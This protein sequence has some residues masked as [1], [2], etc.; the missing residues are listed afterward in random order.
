MGISV[1]LALFAW[2]A[3]SPDIDR[4]VSSALI[5]ELLMALL[6]W[7]CDWIGDRTGVRVG[8]VVG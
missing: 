4:C 7:G 8:V 1:V 3:I 6:I 5:W 2:G